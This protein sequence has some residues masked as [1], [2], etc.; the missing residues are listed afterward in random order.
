MVSDPNR[1]QSKSKARRQPVP[2]PSSA[3]NPLYC[4][5]SETRSD[6]QRR[7]DSEGTSSSMADELTKTVSALRTRL[8]MIGVRL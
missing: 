7:T 8:D 6:A 4:G 3:G 2:K 1:T 5:H